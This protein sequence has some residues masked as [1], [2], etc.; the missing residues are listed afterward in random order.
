MFEKIKDWA[1][2]QH[3]LFGVPAG[4]TENVKWVEI[5]QDLANNMYIP[6]RYTQF[7]DDHR[8]I[9]SAQRE[10][11]GFLKDYVKSH[12]ANLF[13]PESSNDLYHYLISQKG[14]FR[15]ELERGRIQD[16]L[17]YA[18]DDLTDLDLS[19][20][21]DSTIELHT[22]TDYD[23]I[24]KHMHISQ[25]PRSVNFG[26]CIDGKI[27]SISAC[28]EAH[29]PDI[30]TEEIKI[31][32][33]GVGTHEDYRGKGYALSNVVALTAHHLRK[34]RQVAYFTGVS[35][36]AS[37]NVASSAGFT[38]LSQEKMIICFRE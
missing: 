19:K 1:Y 31:L 17:M 4:T 28:N 14:N 6:I 26:T 25:D 11:I 12:E 18:I 3:C 8:L 21:Q 35:N 23:I 37:Q 34:G 30:H 15:E 9:V 22:D 33:I 2:Q 7:V 36:K 29:D 13:S 38:Q 5:S 32:T 16:G 24:E 27:V 20:I 10:H